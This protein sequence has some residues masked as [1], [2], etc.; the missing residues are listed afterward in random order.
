MVL[1]NL[2][3]HAVVLRGTDGDV[4]VPPSGTVARVATAPGVD[5][6]VLAGGVPVFTSPSFGEVEGLGAPSPGT[7]YIVSGLVL[8]RCVGRTDVV[9]PG[10]GPQDGA[11]R[12]E[13]GRIVAVTR[14]I[15]APLA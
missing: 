8:A 13:G 12:D 3:P 9:G 7:M 14:L 2:T 5:S 6:G 11:V 10:T 1:V 4:V 15:R